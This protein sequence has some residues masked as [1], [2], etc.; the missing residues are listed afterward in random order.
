MPISSEFIVAQIQCT[1]AVNSICMN[2]AAMHSHLL[3]VDQFV[4]LFSDPNSNPLTSPLLT[5]LPLQISLYFSAYYVL[6]FTAV[7]FLLFLYKPLALPYPQH[8]IGWEASAFTFLTLIHVIRFYIGN[9]ANLVQSKTAC[10]F[11]LALCVPCLIGHIYLYQWQTYVL[12]VDQILNVIELVFLA[13]EML[14]SLLTLIAFL[15]KPLI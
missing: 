10:I 4:F 6:L 14:A 9:K 2:H 11:F 15:Q 12:R 5:S 1:S 7:T 8:L 3:Y 13:F